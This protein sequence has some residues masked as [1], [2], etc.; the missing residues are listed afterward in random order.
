MK[1][2]ATQRANLITRIEHNRK[3]HKRVRDLEYRLVDVTCRLLRKA[4]REDRKA[5]KQE[6]VA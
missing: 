4:N 3:H 5:A 1:T 6:R 2:L